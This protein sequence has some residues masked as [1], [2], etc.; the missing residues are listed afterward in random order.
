MNTDTPRPDCRQCESN[1]TLRPYGAKVNGMQW[2]VCT[3]CS[4]RALVEL[5]TGV[6]VREGT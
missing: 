6:I 2:H 3:S 1:D 4:K 5:Q